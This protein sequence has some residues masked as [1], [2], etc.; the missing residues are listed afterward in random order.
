MHDF[1]NIVGPIQPRRFS[2]NHKRNTVPLTRSFSSTE[3]VISPP[4]QR[5]TSVVASAT[6]TVT[7]LRSCFRRLRSGSDGSMKSGTAASQA[8]RWL[9]GYAYYYNPLQSHQALDDPTIDR[10][11]R[12]KLTVPRKSI[13]LLLCYSVLFYKLAGD[14][15]SHSG[16]HVG[17]EG[18]AAFLKMVMASDRSSDRGFAL[19]LWLE[20]SKA[21]LAKRSNSDR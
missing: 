19:M 17:S 1:L 3:W 6:P 2:A 21:M 20:C 5:L 13:Y 4:S 7:S 15:T 11:C 9:T 12:A 18:E 14:A 8:E 16:D 10:S